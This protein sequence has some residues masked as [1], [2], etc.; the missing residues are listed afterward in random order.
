M[1]YLWL[2]AAII[3]EVIATSLLKSTAGFTRLLPTVLCLGGYGASF[4]LLSLSIARGMQTGTAYALWAAI[5]TTLIVVAGA[6]FLD[7]PL[8]TATVIGIG[9]IAIGVVTLTTAGGVH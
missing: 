4:F 8:T 9:L 2:A 3:T 7:E 6:M 1:A 5:G